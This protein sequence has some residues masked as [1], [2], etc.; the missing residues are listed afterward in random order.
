MVRAQ[1]FLARRRLHWRQEAAAALTHGAGLLLFAA[2]VPVLITLAALN[3]TAL[4]ITAFSIYGGTLVLLYAASTLYHA[5]RHPRTKHVLRVLD[6][7]AIYL[8]IAGSY[9]PF[10]LLSLDGWVSVVLLTA[11]WSL[12]LVGCVF[13]LFF[14]GRFERLSLAIYLG[15]GWLAVVVAKPV[16]DALPLAALAL[17]VAGGILYTAGVLFYAWQRLPYN[18]AIWH[19]FVLAASICHFAAIAWFAW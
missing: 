2:A 13:K 19:V 1:A 10:A 15:M 11:V 6:H 14:T 9:T 12:A 4:H 3:G 17:L 5:S 8:L 7:A 16:M 18:H